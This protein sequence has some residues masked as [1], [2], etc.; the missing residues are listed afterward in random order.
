MDSYIEI[1]EEFRQSIVDAPVPLRTD[2]LAALKKSPLA[3]DL[4]MWLSYRLF[5]LQRDKQESLTL[6]YGRLQ[7]QFGTSIA[8]ENY[9]N[10]RHELRLAF[11]KVKAQWE[12]LAAADG[13]PGTIH[14]EMN[15]TNLTLYRSKLLIARKDEKSLP[16]A[17]S[18]RSLDAET[19]RKAQQLAGNWDVKALAADYFE[20][21]THKQI[22]PKNLSA[23]FLDFVRE[24]RSR[25]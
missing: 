3:I 22:E 17:S 25:N 2:M 14:C 9:R 21:L 24:H 5:T 18:I 15:E 4:Y 20:W 16:S 19:L 1:S 10:F 12:K 13:N 8:T 11:D 7:E 23:H 6:A